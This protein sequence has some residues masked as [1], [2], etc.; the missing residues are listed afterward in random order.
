MTGLK[1]QAPWTFLCL[2][3]SESRQLA[4]LNK[5]KCLFVKT[6]PAPSKVE[7]K[8]EKHTGLQMGQETFLLQKH[9]DTYHGSL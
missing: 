6:S 9:T 8:V 7:A 2:V 1:I 4:S 3:G 5:T